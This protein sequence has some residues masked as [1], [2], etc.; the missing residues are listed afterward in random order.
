[1]LWILNPRCGEQLHKA[2]ELDNAT[3]CP[4]RPHIGETHGKTITKCQETQQINES[5][6]VLQIILVTR[7]PV[8]PDV[9]IHDLN[10]AKIRR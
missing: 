5:I 10:P 2:M 8:K 6:Q 3:I 9:R 1:M 4:S 7:P